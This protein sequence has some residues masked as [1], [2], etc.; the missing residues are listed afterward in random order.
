VSNVK[1]GIGLVVG[2][3]AGAGIGL[4]AG[5]GLGA[6]AVAGNWVQTNVNN[7]VHTLEVLRAFRANKSDEAID[8]LEMH[9]N[10]H[11]IGLTPAYLKEALVN[12]FLT[13][14][15]EEVK[16]EAI[17]YRTAFGRPASPNLLEKDVAKWLG[18]EL[19]GGVDP[20]TPEPPK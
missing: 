14:Q 15:I 18:L 13:K 1:G 20:K 3:I 11:L 2:L 9:L 4:F 17:A 12:D 7:S 16:Q 19:K 10:K 8:T 6:Q 5:G